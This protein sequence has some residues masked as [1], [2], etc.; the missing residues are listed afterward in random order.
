MNA[1]D[2]KGGYVFVPFGVRHDSPLYALG[3]L[4]KEK[5]DIIKKFAEFVQGEKY[6]SLGTQK[7]FNG[8]NDYK[9][10]LKLKDSSILPAAQKLWKE[11]K[12]GNKP[13]AAVFVADVSGSMDGE[14][15]NRLKESLLKGQKFLGR[16]NSIGFVSYSSSVSINLPIGKYDANQQSMFVG[17]INGLQ[18]G[19]QTAT[20]DA[21]IV[22]LKMLQDELAANPNTKPVIFVLSDGET[23]EGNSLK[24]I[25]ELIESYKVP[26]YTI[27][28]N[29]N[30]QALQDISSI[31]EAASINADTDDVVY[32]IGNLL[33]V[34]M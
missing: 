15:L 33:N 18:A 11:K 30:I 32:K 13:T 7:G 23:N 14:R 19:G 2:L 34:Q 21:I 12:D 9:P 3:N 16:D 27:G 10:Q 5:I 1:A 28:Y 24:E 20:F 22:A 4:P 25:K 31:N 26:I 8:L 17:A 29:A 6:Q